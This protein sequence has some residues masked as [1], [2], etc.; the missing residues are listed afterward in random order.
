M[1]LQATI[2]EDDTDTS[3]ERSEKLVKEQFGLLI[4]KG[5]EAR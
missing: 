3:I 2:D 1:A 5:K 4:K